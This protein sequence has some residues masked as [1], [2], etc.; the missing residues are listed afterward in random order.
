[1]CGYFEC[2][3]E[4]FDKFY[5]LFPEH[6]VLLV[7]TYDTLA[8]ID[9]IIR[10]GL[11]PKAVRLDSGDLLELSQQVR[12]RLDQAGLKET[13]IFAS[14]DLDEFVI[15]DLLARGARIDAFG[16]GTAL[17]TSKDA[18]AL[19]GVYK[20][21]DIESKEGISYRAKLSKD[22]STYP[23][24]KQVYRFSDPNGFFREDLIACADENPSGGTPLLR[25]VMLDGA[26][27]EPSPDLA[28]VQRRAHQETA[29]IPLPCV[30]L[31]NPD[32]Y[33]VTFSDCLQKLLKLVRRQI[34][35]QMEQV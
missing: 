15:T 28:V 11:R 21:V 5:R 19:G 32:P 10:E 29:R 26:Q 6:S 1:M 24:S 34:E 17:T 16:V 2:E 27:V 7:D 25:R 30:R 9:K 8:A 20:L 12:E 22:K 35:E 14:G 3:V 18:P 31:Q 4:A 33:R 13:R 23:G